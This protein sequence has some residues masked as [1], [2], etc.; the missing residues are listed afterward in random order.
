MTQ[1]NRQRRKSMGQETVN[2]IER[3]SYHSASGHEIRIAPQVKQSTENTQLFIE[4]ELEL[5][6]QKATRLSADTARVVPIK[7]T[8]ESSLEAAHRIISKDTTR[9]VGV[10]NF[11]SAKNP[12]GGFLGGSQAQEE[13]LAR[14]SALYAG[15]Q[16]CMEG[17]Y[18]FNRKRSTLLYSD[19][20]IY[21]PECTVFRDDDGALL[22]TPYEI[23]ILTSPAP[24]K[25]AM[26][27]N[28]RG[29]TTQVES[30]FERRIKLMLALFAHKKCDYPVLGAWGCG[31]F[32]NDPKDVAR[33]FYK[34][35]VEEN[36][37]SLFQ[38]VTFAIYEPRKS[39][40]P[41]TQA[42]VAQFELER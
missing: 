27:Q 1:N 31:V 37:A 41:C 17:Y 20:M 23:D 18:Q 8:M 25:G 7:V 2:I 3:G 21:T 16:T 11:A 39:E 38:E 32:G 35:L 42:F 10:L 34:V 30:V 15:L 33:L 26:K 14:S 19:R 6:L 12:G 5:L 40:G 13:S 4:D 28:K 9:Q 24:N 36:F 22:D 29:E